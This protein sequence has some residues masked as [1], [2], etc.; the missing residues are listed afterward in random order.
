MKVMV[1]EIKYLISTIQGFHYF[2][3]KLKTYKVWN[4]NN[5]SILVQM[6]VNL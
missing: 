5:K 3:L 2:V 1:S 4:Q 6:E